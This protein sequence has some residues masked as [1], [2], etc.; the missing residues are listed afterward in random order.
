MLRPVGGE[1]TTESCSGGHL[2]LEGENRPQNAPTD[3]EMLEQVLENQD[4]ILAALDT[5][6]SQDDE[7]RQKINSRPSSSSET[8][9][10]ADADSGGDTTNLS[11]I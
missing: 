7:E 8:S 1:N 11:T 6:H 5:P 4:E 9:K 3:E 10:E 2:T